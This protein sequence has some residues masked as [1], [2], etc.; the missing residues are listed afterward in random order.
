VRL[1][2]LAVLLACTAPALAGPLDPPPGP[3]QSTFKTLNQV[4]PRIEINATNTPGDADSLFK[5]TQPGSYYLTG[6]IAGVVGKHGIEIASSG[7]TIDLGGFDLAGA[8]AMGNF[9]GITATSALL[10]NIAILNGSI[11]NWGDEGIDLATFAVTNCRVTD[12]SASG[13][14]GFGIFTGVAT[15]LSNCS[16][17][18]NSGG[19]INIGVG[20]NAINCSAYNNASNGIVIGFGSTASNCSAYAND[21]SGIATGNSSTVS[22]C[23]VYDNA[24]NGISA[25][26]GSTVT[27][28]AARLN[29]L[30]GILC[31]SQSLILGNTCSFNG[32]VGVGAG[33]R[34]ANSDNRIE[35]NN[36]LLS[37]IGIKVDSA[38]NIIIRNSCSGNTVNWDIVANNIYGPI[39]DRTAPV[40]SSVSGN[41]AASTLGSTDPNANFT[42]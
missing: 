41:A 2:A 42:Y 16:A 23:S 12:V 8:P 6:N 25:G 40:S 32:Q 35:G 28:N 26:S 14:T 20:S 18:Q 34:V 11:R 33:I 21:G 36:C 27:H 15:T 24:A 17:S 4:E 39:L 29:S 1:T 10:T 37:D 13:C 5:I 38:G 30:D 7:V 31:G 9:D 3:V 19:G 22:G